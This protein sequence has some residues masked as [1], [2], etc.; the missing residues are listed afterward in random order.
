MEELFE[1]YINLRHI[2]L[3]CDIMTN[4]GILTPINRQG[5]NIGDTGPLGKCSFEDT[6][7]QLIKA[8]LYG[9]VDHLQGVSSNIMLGQL[10]HSG[11]GMC[12]ILLDE[13]KLIDSLSNINQTVEDFIEV[14]ENNIDSLMEDEN[15]NEY[16]NEDDF[17][18]SV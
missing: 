1:E 9:E 17:N 6:T 5:I 18:F 12:D 2:G 15:E 13:E 11:T 10:I 8:G 3:L 14:S 7:D 4:K 16:C